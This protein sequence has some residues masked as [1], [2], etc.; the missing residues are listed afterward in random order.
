MQTTGQKTVTIIAFILLLLL[1][2]GIVLNVLTSNVI[3][4][5]L[6][7]PL[8]VKIILETIG[9]RTL[10]YS[11]VVSLIALILSAIGRAKNT[12]QIAKNVFWMSLVMFILTIFATLLLIGWLYIIALSLPKIHS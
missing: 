4:D 2:I 5:L 1:W 8:E 12:D 7:M 9:A 10:F 3:S 11:P 6:R